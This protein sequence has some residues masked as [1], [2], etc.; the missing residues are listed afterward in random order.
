MG[1][2]IWNVL[3][4][5]RK[6]ALVHRLLFQLSTSNEGPQST[7]KTAQEVVEVPLFSPNQVIWNPK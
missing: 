2:S 5:L 7:V 3:A 1:S 4:H 6:I